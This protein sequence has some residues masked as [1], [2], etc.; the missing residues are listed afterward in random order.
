[1]NQLRNGMK[2]VERE[3][4][5]FR[6]QPVING[7]RYLPVMKEF[8]VKASVRLAEL[9][10]LFIDMKARFD[11]VCRLFC[12]DPVT[13]SSDDFFGIFDFY[14]TNFL[15]AKQENDAVKRKKE[16]EEKMAKQQQELRMRTLERK[17]SLTASKSGAAK[18]V[19]PSTSGAKNEFDDLISALR[20]GDV[21]GENMDKFRGGNGTGSV[22][23]NHRKFRHSPPRPGQ[24]DRMDSFLRERPTTN[25]RQ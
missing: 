22:N 12:E 8:S 15:E 1:M 19:A 20:T 6:T 9:E 13:T 16:E 23:R 14:T 2:E 5:F 25:Q 3:V 4:E 10:D 11:R 21:F 7:D 24:L 18:K 17:K